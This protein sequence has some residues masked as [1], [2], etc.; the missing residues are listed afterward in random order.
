MNLTE[1]TL[2]QSYRYKGRIINLRVD[3]ARLPNGKIASREVVEHPGGVCVAALTDDLEVLMVRQFRY[4]YG[5]IVLEAPAGKR[6]KGED[7][8]LCGIREL[9]EETG[10]AAENYRFMGEL[11]P[12]PGYC[13][14]IIYLYLATGL[15]FSQMSPDED[16][17]LECERIPLQRLVDMALSGEIRDAKTQALILKIEA[18]RVR[19]E[20]PGKEK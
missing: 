17:F 19:G 13:G 15:T 6:E 10:A 20:L 16:E 18:L 4:P 12:S 3:E 2:S 5:E 14:E 1:E 7:P 8:L 9:K 11:Y